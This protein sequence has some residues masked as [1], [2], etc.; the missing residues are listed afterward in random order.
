MRRSARS[1]RVPWR[2]VGTVVLVAA[3]PFTLHTYTAYAQIEA[4]SAQKEQHAAEE[5]ARRAREEESRRLG[6]SIVGMRESLTGRPFDPGFRETVKRKLLDVPVEALRDIE[7]DGARGDLGA[8]ISGGGGPESADQDLLLL[9][10]RVAEP[11]AVSG[12]AQTGYVYVPVTPCRIVDTRLSPAGPL[13]PGVVRP[14]V[15]SGAN[16]TLFEAQG[17]SATGCG[18][19]AGTATAA[20][21][22]FVSVSPAGPGNLRAWAYAASIPAP[23]LASILNYAAVPGALNIANG[24]VAP[25]CDPLA[26]ACT[27]DLLVRADA[28]STDVVADVLGYF[29]PAPTSFVVPG[30]SASLVPIGTSC[31]PYS[32]ALVGVN[33]P[34][35]GKVLVEANLQLE[36][37]HT[38]FGFEFLTLSIGN[39]PTSCS[40]GVGDISYVSMN[41]QPTGYYYPSVVISRLFTVS[42]PGTYYYYVNG[43]ANAGDHSKFWNAGVKAT[44]HPN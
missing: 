10:S 13:P 11:A 29:R 2:V 19:P 20:F 7:R 28:S 43:Y 25:L 34:A 18:I 35:P 37:N 12:V 27:Y 9:P 6:E 33:V 32:G 38:Q 17:G 15:V 44:F 24:I 22:N 8:A 40:G 42:T 23:P 3:A 4:V 36:I 39:G 5:A 30:G 31:T 21:V 14:F 41:T 1:V 26:T 16:A